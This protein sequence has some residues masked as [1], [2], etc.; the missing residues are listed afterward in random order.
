MVA[1][2]KFEANNYFPPFF[3]TPIIPSPASVYIHGETSPLPSAGAHKGG[4]IVLCP[5]LWSTQPYPSWKMAPL[6]TFYGVRPATLSEA[7]GCESQ[8]FCVERRESI[9]IAVIIADRCCWCRALPVPPAPGPSTTEI[10]H[11]PTLTLP[12]AHMCNPSTIP[13]VVHRYNGITFPMPC[14]WCTQGRLVLVLPHTFWGGTGSQ[15]LVVVNAN[16][17]SPAVPWCAGGKRWAQ[18]RGLVSTLTPLRRRG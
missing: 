9:I 8:E 2:V 12:H 3:P 5:L 11:S 13:V 7:R 17:L 6:N 16:G 4:H 18:G 10:R 1:V 14:V 15:P